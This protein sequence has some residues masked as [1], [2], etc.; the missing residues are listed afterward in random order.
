M[1]RVTWDGRISNPGTV[2][3]SDRMLIERYSHVMHIVSNVVG[4]IREGEDALSALLAGL[5]AGTVSGAPKVR[6]MEIIA[7]L[8]SEQRDNYAGAVGYFGYNGN[9]DTCIAL[10]T[11]VVQ[12][13]TAYVQAGAGIV[14]DSDPETEEEETENKAA[15][16]LAALA[17]QAFFGP[18]APHLKEEHLAIFDYLCVSASLEDRVVEYVEQP[19]LLNDIAQLLRAG[20]RPP[21]SRNVNL[22]LRRLQGIPDFA[23]PSLEVALAAA[24][25]SA[26][27]YIGGVITA[28]ENAGDPS[29][30][31]W[32]YTMEVTWDTGEQSYRRWLEDPTFDRSLL[33]VAFDGDDVLAGVEERLV[34]EVGSRGIA[35]GDVDLAPLGSLVETH[36]GDS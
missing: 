17:N 7:E 9:M 21:H 28:E 1:Y 31:A 3:V 26:Q 5:P 11:I 24:P 30:G 23:S 6:A 12:G 20:A 36:C 29:L 22:K 8:E 19:E 14:A 16:L 35:G 4:E 32:C 10:R 18:L 13:D 27:C 25:A 34:A 33:V 15:A 2:V